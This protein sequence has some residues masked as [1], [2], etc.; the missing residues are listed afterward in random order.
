LKGIDI[1]CKRSNFVAVLVVPLTGLALLEPLDTGIRRREAGIEGEDIDS[2]SASPCGPA[3]P[4]RPGND[5]LR[6][7][8]E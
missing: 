8:C 7:R 1:L 2:P 6:R 4:P 3:Q 5:F